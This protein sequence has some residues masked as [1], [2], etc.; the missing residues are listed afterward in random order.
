[1][2]RRLPRYRPGPFTADQIRDGDYYEL[3]HGHPIECSPAGR[4]HTGPNVSGPR[5]VPE[6]VFTDYRAP[7]NRAAPPIHCGAG[8]THAPQPSSSAA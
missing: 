4:D 7:L 1:M 6:S 3:S 5:L 2:S 8:P